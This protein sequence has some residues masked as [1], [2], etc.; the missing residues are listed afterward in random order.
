MSLLTL[1]DGQQVETRNISKVELFE[2]DQN[3]LITL[4][5]GHILGVHGSGVVNDANLLDNINEANHP[6][7]TIYRKSKSSNR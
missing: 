3:L 5:T 6:T 2:E 4:K 1:S 7:Y